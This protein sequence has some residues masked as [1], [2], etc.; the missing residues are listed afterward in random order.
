MPQ[1]AGLRF[2]VF[3]LFPEI[4]Q[5]Y[6]GQ[7]ILKLALDEGLVEIHLWNIRDWAKGKHRSVDDRPFGGGPGMV[8]MPEPVFDA[9]E[10]VRPRAADPGLLLLLTLPACTIER[11][12]EGKPFADDFEAA[13]LGPAW[14][15]T[16]GK[17]R[18]D[19]GELVIDHGYN[20][21]LWLTSALPRDGVVEVD[22]W[23]N[24]EAGDIKLELWGDGK[25]F[26]T[27]ASYTATSYVF[28]FGGWHNTISAIARMRCE[29]ASRMRVRTCA[30][31]TLG[32]SSKRATSGSGFFSAKTAIR[33]TWSASVIGLS[34]MTDSGTE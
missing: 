25:S 16:G 4:F 23:S 24:D 32:P 6:L 3:T 29:S 12:P 7:S 22:A 30:M 26:A 11:Q 34:T 1:G 17:Y 15:S 33:T 5:G 31:P 14:K 21:P 10:A 19:K 27:E 13:A 2:D 8:L 28:I 9:V 20:H 18:V